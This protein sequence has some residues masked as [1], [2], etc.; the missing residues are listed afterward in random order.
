[1]ILERESLG[2]GWEIPGPPTRCMK[3][4][5][6]QIESPLLQS[7][8]LLLKDNGLVW[9]VL[10]LSLGSPVFSACN[11][12]KLGIGSGNEAT[13]KPLSKGYLGTSTVCP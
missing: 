6:G 7:V 4:C 2:W 1:M 5:I 8:G 9:L 10:A 3:P 13:V 11:I 12:Q